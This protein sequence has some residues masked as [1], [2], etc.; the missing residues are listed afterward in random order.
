MS[1]IIVETAFKYF[2]KINENK[3]GIFRNQKRLGIYC[4]CIY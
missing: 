3:K 4:A 1:E 2:K